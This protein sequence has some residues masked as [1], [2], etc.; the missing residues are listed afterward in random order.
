METE[1]FDVYGCVGK[2]FTFTAT[3]VTFT[4]PYAFDEWP[5]FFLITTRPSEEKDIDI[6]VIL[7]G[8]AVLFP[9]Q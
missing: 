5:F 3:L 1:L 8:N 4:A 6:L 2:Y 7:V 9:R